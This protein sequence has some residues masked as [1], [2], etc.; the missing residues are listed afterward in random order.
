MRIQ[1]RKQRFI[2]MTPIQVEADD[3]TKR[4]HATIGAASGDHRSA[5]PAQL[6]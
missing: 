5:L 3:L 4:M 2:A 6:S 1:G